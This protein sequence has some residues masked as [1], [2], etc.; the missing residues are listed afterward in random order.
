[1]KLNFAKRMSYIKASEIRDKSHRTGRCDFVVQ[2]S[3]FTV[4]SSML[5]VS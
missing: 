1:M 3:L 2:D 4:S 5:I